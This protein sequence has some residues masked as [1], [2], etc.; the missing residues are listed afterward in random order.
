M[1]A[2]PVLS[3]QGLS[4]LRDQAVI[5]KD[6]HWEI[7]QGEHWVVLGPNGCGKT[8]LLRAITGYLP[9]TRG[10]ISVLGKT[11][12]ES[13][14]RELRKRIGFVSANL[15]QQIESAETALEVVASG[16]HALLNSWERIPRAE[17]QEAMRILRDVHAEK[18]ANRHWL[19][20]SQGERQRILIGR[21]LMARPRLL[22]LDE[23]CAGLDPLARERFL[24]FIETLARLEDAPGMILVT[25]HVE[26]ILPAF[27]RALILGSGQVVAAGPLRQALT[28]SHLSQA[29]G[30][31][32]RLSRHSRHRG[33]KS[34]FR[35]EL[36]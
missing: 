33:H 27:T 19:F 1:D 21:A 3:I 15:A 22:I 10:E 29:F 5:L 4:I 17:R 35:I 32:I 2:P 11:Y 24:D 13:D 16:R 14:W 8:S 12:G 26:E 30:H 9:P 31:P 20:L 28:S 23:P 36:D 6:L 25:H 34:R 7:R 18:L